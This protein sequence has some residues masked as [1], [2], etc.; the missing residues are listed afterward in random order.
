MKIRQFL[1]LPFLFCISCGS[2]YKGYT[3]ENYFKEFAVSNNTEESI[4]EF[5]D[6]YKLPTSE[7][8]DQVGPYYSNSYLYY[9]SAIN[10]SRIY[11]ET[12]L[13]RKLDDC[14]TIYYDP[15]E[16][17]TIYDALGNSYSLGYDVEASDLRAKS[18]S[19][20]VSNKSS[21]YSTLVNDFPENET[22]VCLDTLK[23]YVTSSVED[24]DLPI[25]L[26]QK[27]DTSYLLD[28]RYM[29]N[30]DYYD[31][32]QLLYDL[33][34][35]VI[36]K[37]K[38]IIFNTKDDLSTHIVFLDEENLNLGLNPSYTPYYY[39]GV[40]VGT[41]DN[42]IFEKHENLAFSVCL[43]DSNF[44]NY[45][46]DE[47]NVIN[48]D[49]DFI[50]DGKQY[51]VYMNGV[52]ED[53]VD[54]YPLDYRLSASG[55]YLFVL[56]K[57]IT[58]DKALTNLNYVIGID[59][60]GKIELLNNDLISIFTNSENYIYFDGNFIKLYDYENLVYKLNDEFYITESN[61]YVTIVFSNGNTSS[62][63]NYEF[64]KCTKD[65]IYLKYTDGSNY[66]KISRD[67]TL[68]YAINVDK[69]LSWNFMFYINGSIFN[70]DDV[71]LDLNYT[72]GDQIYLQSR[73]AIQ[74]FN[75]KYYCEL[76]DFNDYTETEYFLVLN[77]NVLNTN[78]L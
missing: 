33:N 11:A 20:F 22:I 4:V 48:N 28:S 24:N 72:T 56:C 54:F 13:S 77:G 78:E 76:W 38:F 14:F 64:Y 12:L 31:T 32:M 35:I 21:F 66:E 10:D 15:Q 40:C 62:Y 16:P 25:L 75:V 51:K 67:G 5:E 73:F 17:H 2:K 60:T 6:A 71:V 19:L 65:S 39:Y 1:I 37:D 18:Y 27:D 34:D 61:N 74:T 26:K 57:K 55:D 68:S 58:A 59:E 53:V 36:K 9:E 70:V 41:L 45:S 69:M 52:S 49:F 50:K 44:V 8:I 29:R 42:P 3:S 7:L 46:Y 43:G 30:I 23:L 63:S 47:V